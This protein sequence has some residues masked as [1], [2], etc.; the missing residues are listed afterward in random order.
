MSAGLEH[1]R[2]VLFDLDGTLLDTAPDMAGA[3]NALLQEEGLAGLPFEAI[4]ARVSHGAGA[5][6]RLAFPHTTDAALEELRR[7]FLD[8]YNNRLSVESRLFDGLNEALD[9]LDSRGI[10][11]GIV[12]NK[13][14]WLTEPLLEQLAL[15]QRAAVVVSGDTLTERKP[16]PAPLWYAAER[17]GAAPN[18]CIYIGDA[19][20]DVLAAKAA[21]MAAYVALFGYILPD[22]HPQ[23]WPAD[24]WLETPQSLGQLLRS[25]ATPPGI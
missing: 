16:H 7:R 18:L 11:W 14:G 22:E 15:R 19:E 25:L 24:G 2:A 23:E 17:L 4:R 10:P 9:D 20:R 6:V 3:L 21:G 12:T 8:L 13:P 1:I 5:V